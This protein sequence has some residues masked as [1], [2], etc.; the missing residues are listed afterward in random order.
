MIPKRISD[1]NG[2]V[3]ELIGSVER[4]GEARDHYVAHD[5]SKG[6]SYTVNDHKVRVHI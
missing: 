1:R 4:M 6:D 3:M 5:F 2:K